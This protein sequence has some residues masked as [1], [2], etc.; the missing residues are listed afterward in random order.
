MF[1]IRMLLL[2]IM[3][4]FVCGLSVNPVYAGELQTPEENRGFKDIEQNSQDGSEEEI[5]NDTGEQTSDDTKEEVQN[6]IEKEKATENSEESNSIEQ[7]S[8]IV[9]QKAGEDAPINLKINLLSEPYGIKKDQISF[10]WENADFDGMKFQ[11]SYRIVVSKR[12]ADV[13]NGKYIYDTGWVKSKKNSSV[14]YNLSEILNDNELYYWQVQ[15]KGEEGKESSLSDPQAFSTAVENEWSDIQGIWGSAGQKIVMFRSEIDCPSGVEKVL[16]N[17]TASSSQK[18]SQYVYNLYVNGDEIGV[19]PVRENEGKLYYNTYD[20]TENLKKGENAIGAIAYSE[21]ASSFLCQVTYYM[22]DGTHYIKTNTATDKE[23]WKVLDSD[24]V[25]IGN[26]MV[27]IGTS[28]YVARR[29]N[30]N[31]S[32]FPFGW[33]NSGFDD[34]MWKTPINNEIISQ[35]TLVSSELANM[36]RYEVVPKSISRI[37]DDSYMIDMGKE[38]VGTIRLNMN[39]SAGKIN[40]KYGEELNEDGSVRSKLDTGNTYEET[41]SLISGSQELSGIGMKTFRYISISNLPN[42]FTLNSIIGL[43]VRQEFDEQD[44]NFT[45]SNKILNEIY[46][47]SK[48]T[49]KATT[50]DLYVDSQN[51]ERM[52]Y[53]GDSLITAMNS[54]SFSESSTSAKVTAEYLLNNTTW[55]AEYSLYNIILIYENYL[56]TG[57]IR[58][59]ENSYLLLKEKTLENYFDSSRGLMKAIEDGGVYDQHIMTDWPT[60]EQDGYRT[61]ESYYNTVFNAVCVGAYA[62]MAKIADVLGYED[63]KEYYEN[64]SSVIKENMIAK[65]YNSETGEFYDGLMRNGELV[66]HSAQHATAYAL[67]FHIYTNQNMADQMCAAIEADGELK[68]SVYGT[69]F[70]LQGLYESNHGTLARKIMSNPNDELG[71]RSWAYM[72]YGQKATITT[73][74]WDN[75]RKNNM[76]MAHAWGS[77]PGSMLIRGM[78][79]IRPLQAGY[80]KFQIKL[81]P[82]GIKNASVKVPTL[83][84]K[85]QVSYNIDDKG[86]ISGEIYVPTNSK[87]VFQVPCYIATPDLYIDGIKVEAENIENFLTYEIGPGMHTYQALVGIFVDEAE[88]VE[89]DISYSAYRNSIWTEWTTNITPI[90]N[91]TNSQIEAIKLKIRNQKYSGDIQYAVHMQSYGWQDWIEGGNEAGIV[92]GGK[93]VEAFRVKLTGEIEKYYDVYYRANVE[94][95]GWLDWTSNGEPAGSSDFGK[96]LLNFQVTLVKKDAAPPGNTTSSFISKEKDIYY[97]THVQNSGWQV[98]CG[99]GEISGT[100]GSSKRLEAIRIYFNDKI[101]GEVRYKTHVQSYGWQDWKSNGIVSGTTGESKRL[102]AIKIQLTGEASNKYDIY[103]RVHV[104]NFGWLDW[105]SNGEPAGS[106]GYSRRLEAIQIKLVKKGE[107]APGETANTFK[108][109]IVSYR[110]HVQNY[111]WQQYVHN[112]QMSGTNGQSKRLEAIQIKK[113]DSNISGHIQYKTHIESHGWES[114][115]K[116]EGEVSGTS[117]QSKRLEAICIQLTGDLSKLYDI[118]YRVHIQDYGWLDWASNG[119]PAGSEGMS[120]RLESI[121]IEL[122]EKDKHI[123]GTTYC[124][125]ISAENKVAYSS[126]VQDIGWQVPRYDGMI[127]GTSGESKR[128]EAVKIWISNPDINGNV[129]Y[130]SFVQGEGWTDWV[131]DGKISG[132]TGKEKRLEAIQIKLTGKVKEKYDVYY[133]VHA[134]SYGWLGWTS[135]GKT[136]GVPNKDRRIEAVQIML[137]SKGE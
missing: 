60:T 9:F 116:Q 84:G 88:W 136:A 61:Q 16:I 53:E 43:M 117:G 70:L 1:K 69:Y 73:E 46:E 110:T 100:V 29:D 34:S 107:A 31:A 59:L 56:N 74:F 55:P 127:S 17:I 132:T 108:K 50:Q 23:N 122:V 51:R 54:Y 131:S 128:I 28:F 49:C 30:L 85:I 94:D 123:T 57:D 130:R 125:F 14:I 96:R 89:E 35:Y 137:L 133:R 71:V 8:G 97:E 4:L 32:K 6:N 33:N 104:Q 45:S 52:P 103:Y 124:P 102:E 99:D 82:G 65:L 13:E 7:E 24:E 26:N 72:M 98:A 25:F 63:D 47:L 79:G 5:S 48:Y 135:S 112:G 87:A 37:D 38:I 19:G 15:I 91:K 126:Y 77:S 92:N 64:L 41:W 78:F 62:D 39:S 42:G 118:Y 120:K 68:M 22:E 18:T 81:Q 80:E 66:Q 75:V 119:E 40:I 10:S 90:R 134:Q 58:G 11:Q 106:E 67:A 76:S 114:K 36:K 83:K 113:S 101:S 105:A 95:Y 115:W 129:E 21:N 27:S 121:E 109:A 2:I 93:R 111:G 20:I 12:V 86:V 3:I 44:S